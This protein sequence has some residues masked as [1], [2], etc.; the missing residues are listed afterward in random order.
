MIT[1]F[2]KVIVLHNPDYIHG[3][4]V[5]ITKCQNPSM[6]NSEFT[7]PCFKDYN[8]SRKGC[9]YFSSTI[10]YDCNYIAF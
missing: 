5:W 2:I 1:L 7:K 9:N 10:D 8:K 6:H 3:Y 4:I